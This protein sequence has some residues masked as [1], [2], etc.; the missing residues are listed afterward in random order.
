MYGVGAHD[1]ANLML[2]EV[3]KDRWRE[4]IVGDDLERFLKTTLDRDDRVLS[5]DKAAFA[6][7]DRKHGLPWPSP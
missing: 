2:W 3:P 6:E 1:F 7:H 5:R 4:Y